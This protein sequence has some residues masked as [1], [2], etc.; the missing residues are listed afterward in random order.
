MVGVAVGRGCALPVR[1]CVP[2][3]R[4]VPALEGLLVSLVVT[5]CALG[6][7]TKHEHSKLQD[8]VLVGTRDMAVSL[9]VDVTTCRTE[10]VVPEI[11]VMLVTP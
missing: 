5:L 8:T 3:L 7:T 1:F 10:W 4:L 6:I 9:G 11:H 2:L